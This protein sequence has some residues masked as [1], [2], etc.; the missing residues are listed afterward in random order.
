MKTAQVSGIFG[1]CY[2]MSVRFPEETNYSVDVVLNFISEKIVQCTHSQATLSSNRPHEVFSTESGAGQSTDDAALCI[3]EINCPYCEQEQKDQ[4]IYLLKRLQAA[5]QKGE[6]E[7]WDISHPRVRLLAEYTG[8]SQNE[9]R[10]WWAL[11]ACIRGADL[12]KFCEGE[13]IRVVFSEQ[14]ATPTSSLSLNDPHYSAPLPLATWEDGDCKTN[15]TT[16]SPSRPCPEMGNTFIRKLVFD[17]AWE[18]ECRQRGKQATPAQVIQELKRLATS[19]S[20][21]PDQSRLIDTFAGG[22]VWVTAKGEER[23][24]KVEACGKALGEWRMARRKLGG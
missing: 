15:N 16:E 17:I 12:A 4:K 1:F 9:N 24:F 3:K 2:T 19:D 7:L 20:E 8:M 10:K 11:N 23:K 5:V 18:I 21:N 14:Q 22:V 13:K 6:F